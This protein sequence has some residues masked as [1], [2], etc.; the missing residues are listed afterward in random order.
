MSMDN[1]NMKRE[2]LLHKYLNGT[3]SPEEIETLRQDDRYALYVT[4]ADAS[5]EFEPPAFDGQK[6]FIEIESKKQGVSKVRSLNPART[7]LKVAAAVAILFVG[8]LLFQ[9]G[10]TTISTQ[11][12]EKQE[13]LLPDASEVHLNAKTKISYYKNSWDSDRTLE[14]D[15]E[16]FFKVKKGSNFSVNTTHGIVEVV[17]TEFNV[18]VRDSL[19]QISCYEGLVRVS[20]AD[21]S[22]EVPAGTRIQ[23]INQKNLRKSAT[24]AVSPNWITNESTFENVSLSLVLEELKRQYPIK[25]TSHTIVDKKFTGSFTHKDLNVALRSICDPLQVEFTISGEEVTLHAKKNN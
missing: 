25:I 24:V 12:A 18:F 6:N 1:E 13:I 10:E 3:A 22:L 15:G 16:A 19:F 11:V 20:Y 14:L 5:K 7:W 17:G 8:F 4:I 21:K 9:N 23:L 2:E